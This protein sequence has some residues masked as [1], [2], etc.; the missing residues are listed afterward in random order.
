MNAVVLQ[1]HL[2]VDLE[3]KNPK[4]KT[5]LDPMN[6][7]IDLVIFNYIKKNVLY[8]RK[9]EKKKYFGLLTLFFTATATEVYWWQHYQIGE[10]CKYW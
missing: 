7:N 5:T 8:Q 2:K 10:Y 1:S 6:V 4:K 9:K 3:F